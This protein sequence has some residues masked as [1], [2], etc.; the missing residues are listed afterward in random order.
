M[1]NKSEHEYTRAEW[2]QRF[3]HGERKFQAMRHANAVAAAAGQGLPVSRRVLRDYRS[4]HSHPQFRSAMEARG[5]DPTPVT[6]GCVATRPSK[7]TINF[8]DA[9]LQILQGSLQLHSIQET[10]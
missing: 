9:A 8:Y 5:L 4:I 10:E 1:P 3:P 6:V 2:L 7:R